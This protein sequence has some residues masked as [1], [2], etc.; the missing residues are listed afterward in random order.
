M[1]N[2]TQYHWSI[3]SNITQYHWSM[4]NITQCRR[5][6]SNITQYHWSM[7]NITQCRWSMSNLTQY[8]WSMLDIIQYH[9]SMSNITPL[10]YYVK[11]NAIPR[12]YVKYNSIPLVYVKY[13]SNHCIMCHITPI[14]QN[15]SMHLTCNHKDIIRNNTTTVGS[16]T[17]FSLK[18]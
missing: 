2:I 6:M 8:H 16:Q 17:I 13:N 14:L 11:Y 12:V 7:S 3:M 5:S 9:W 18:N 15:S 1:S 4:S 10:V